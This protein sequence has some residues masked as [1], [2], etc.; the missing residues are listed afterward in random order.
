MKTRE[1]LF[2]KWQELSQRIKMLGS[3][4][5]NPV[6]NI[7]YE[8]FNEQRELYNSL[9]REL[10]SLYDET[11]QYVYNNCSSRWL[12]NGEMID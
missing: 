2:N 6:D 5:Q 1:Q 8:N 4:V 12:E 11:M 9:K 10:D 7:S 3:I